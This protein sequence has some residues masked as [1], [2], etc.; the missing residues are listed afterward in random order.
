ML[1]THPAGLFTAHPGLNSLALALFTQGV[2][3]LQPTKTPGAKKAGF[4][5]HQRFQ[6]SAVPLLVAGSAAVFASKLA[7]GGKHFRTWHSWFGLAAEGLLFGQILIGA[8]LVYAPKLV[9]GQRIANE[10]I[11]HHR[12]GGYLT[13]GLAFSTP[14]L[15]MG[16]SDFMLKNASQ[17]E[18]VAMIGGLGLSFAGVLA[19]MHPSKLLGR[20][21]HTSD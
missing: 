1:L 3:V 5:W 17:G 15:A 4:T 21:P 11:H 18:R 20:A 2:L 13:L 6:L 9:G 7:H 16:W 19:R 12:L 14:V 8:V 10:L